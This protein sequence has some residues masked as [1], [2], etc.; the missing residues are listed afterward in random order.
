MNQVL[1]NVPKFFSPYLYSFRKKTCINSRV[2]VRLYERSRVESMRIERSYI[3]SGCVIK[4]TSC[5]LLALVVRTIALLIL[6]WCITRCTFCTPF[7]HFAHP[8][9]THSA[10]SAV[11]ELE[12][13]GDLGGRVGGCSAEHVC[14]SGAFRRVARVGLLLPTIP[15]CPTLGCVFSTSYSS[16]HYFLF[17]LHHSLHIFPMRFR[18]FQGACGVEKN[19]PR[20]IPAPPPPLPR[21]IAC[22]TVGFEH[23]RKKTTSTDNTKILHRWKILYAL[24]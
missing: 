13:D 14:T 12:C 3:F 16:F 8:L 23:F 19:S 22:T 2:Y 24:P 18:V 10:G 11:P 4:V 21:P 6:L 7:A 5:S 1:P 20:K 17:F 15:L 9:H